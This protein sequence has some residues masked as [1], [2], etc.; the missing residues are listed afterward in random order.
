MM[1]SV[2]IKVENVSKSFKLYNSP[3]DRLKESLFFNRKKC[4]IDHH[5]LDNISFEICKGETIGIIGANGAGKSTLLKIITGVLNPTSGHVDIN[6]K[7][8]SLLELGVGFNPEMTGLQNIF[9]Y[10]SILGF[11]RKD[12]EKKVDKV[13]EFADIGEYIYQP[14]KTYSSGMFVRLAFAVNTVIDPDILIVD[15][16][17]AVGDMLFVQKCM[18]FI[19]RFKENGTLLFVSHDLG[20]LKNLCDR[21]IW[22]D[23][24][25]IAAMGSSADVCDRYLDFIYKKNHDHTIENK[26]SVMKNNSDT[27][28]NLKKYSVEEEDNHNRVVFIS[29]FEHSDSFKTGKAELINFSISHNKKITNRNY[30][31]GGDKV[32]FCLRGQVLQPLDNPILGFLVKDKLGQELFGDNTLNVANNSRLEAREGNILEGKFIFN[33]PRLQNG[34][35]SILLSFAEGDHINHTQHHLIHDAYI[36]TVSSEEITFG[37]MNIEFDEVSLELVN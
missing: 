37:I 6:G 27:Y 15:E 32:I 22:I 33:L 31:K 30:F 35:Y 5:V 2:L 7:V 18:R 9:F 14:V 19:R 13:L 29:N 16:A 4:H 36:M 21:A 10:G 17:L 24:G 25:K 3:K 28:D 23:N 34:Q 12:M 20:S 1:N 11:S 8:A 26:K